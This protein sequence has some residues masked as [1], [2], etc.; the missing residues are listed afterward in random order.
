MRSDDNFGS[1]L[2]RCDTTLARSENIGLPRSGTSRPR[3]P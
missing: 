3:R 1:V 2:H